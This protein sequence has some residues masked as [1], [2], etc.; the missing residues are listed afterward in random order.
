MVDKEHDKLEAVKYFEKLDRWASSLHGSCYS[1]K[2][3]KI[4]ESYSFA[5]LEINRIL[6]NSK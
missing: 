5:Q 1:H 2:K 4:Q 6:N 3:R